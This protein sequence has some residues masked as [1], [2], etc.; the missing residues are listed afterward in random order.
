MYKKIKAKTQGRNDEAMRRNKIWAGR[1]QE[2]SR[3]KKNCHGGKQL[4]EGIVEN[5]Y[6][7]IYRRENRKK[8]K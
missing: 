2:V 6:S 7:K 3:R 4:G 5:M 1:T 8:L